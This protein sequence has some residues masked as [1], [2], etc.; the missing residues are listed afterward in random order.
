MTGAMLRRV[1]QGVCVMG[2]VLTALALLRRPN[3]DA[4]PVDVTLPRVGAPDTAGATIDPALLDRIVDGNIF[5]PAHRRPANRTTVASASPSSEPPPMPGADAGVAPVAADSLAPARVDAVPR[6][7]GVI[8]DAEG[9]GALLR[10]S[11]AQA[12]ALLYREGDRGGPYRV[13]R[14]D[15]DRVALDGPRGAL[16]LRLAPPRISP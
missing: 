13:R 2:V 12:G 4:A 14:I 8:T 11:R 3:V 15:P 5:S 9:R 1:L 7:Y 6:L 16:V 10:L